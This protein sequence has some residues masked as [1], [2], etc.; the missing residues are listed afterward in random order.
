MHVCK[1]RILGNW[2]ILMLKV[3]HWHLSIG[4]ICGSICKPYNGGH[5]DLEWCNVSELLVPWWEIYFLLSGFYCIVMRFT[6]QGA[7]VFLN[8]DRFLFYYNDSTAFQIVFEFLGKEVVLDY[9][10]T[11]N[12]RP[13]GW[14]GNQWGICPQSLANWTQFFRLC[15]A[16]S[17]H[18]TLI[19]LSWHLH[20]S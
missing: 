8:Y 15:R 16:T 10:C 13:L 7:F 3:I 4:L 18:P 20:S 17:I 11:C 14:F 9:S 1:I 2:A 6:T 12:Y 5:C 19:L